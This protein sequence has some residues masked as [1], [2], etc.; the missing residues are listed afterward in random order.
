VSKAGKGKARRMW[1]PRG[2]FQRKKIGFI[3]RNKVGIKEL[4]EFQ[5]CVIKS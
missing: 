2:N 1:V 3:D 4:G 5:A